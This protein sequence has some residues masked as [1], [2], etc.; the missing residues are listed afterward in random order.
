MRILTAGLAF[1]FLL[2]LSACG[3]GGSGT[4]PVNSVSLTLASPSGLIFTGQSG[5]T[6]NLTV[7]RQGTVGNV[8]L[9]VQGLPA[10]AAADIT[11]PNSS[12]AG[13]IT[14]MAPTAAAATYPL[15][16]T[17]S[18]GSVSDSATF[19][20]VVGA[21]AQI[22]ATSNGP[23]QLAMATSFQPAEWDYQ[24]FTL[25]PTATTTLQN[26]QSQHTRLQGISGGVPQKTLAAWDFT[27]L[28][29]ITQPVLGVG[30][31]SPEF[32]IAK[33]PPTLYTGNDSNNSFRDLTFQE[34]GDYS[35]ELVRYYNTGG[36]TSGDG[37]FHISPAYPQDV[38]TWWGI[39]NEP[40][41]NNKLT[42]QQYVDLYNVTVPQMQAVDPSL[43]YVA[44]ELADFGS[45]P[46]NWVPPFVNGVTAHVDVMAT[47]F[48][49]T[50]NQKDNDA[51]I[52]A[53]IPG[54]ISDVRF[55]YTQMAT[56][57]ALANVPL[58]VTE[59]NVNADF[60]KGGGISAC[61]GGAF[62]TDLRGSSAFFAAWR[63]Y[64]F[65]QFGKAGVEA[66]Y[67]WDFDADKQY[68]EVDYNT[69]AFQLS[70]WVDY[71]LARMF[72]SPP[73]ATLLDYTA[74]DKT[75]L[76]ILPVRNA[77]NSVTVMVANYALHSAGDNN[78]PGSPRTVQ[79][80]TSAFGAFASASLLTIDAS[81]NVATGPTATSVTPAA[82]INI[83]LN[84]YGVAFLTLK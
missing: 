71:W 68:G 26:L 53:T 78:G 49:S 62:V 5:T 81:T 23:F 46:Q 59:N 27:V 25:N 16:V 80:D 34:F 70:Y 64:V 48:Y 6:I 22:G 51:T 65:S 74:T 55:F 60:D 45:E 21:V 4:Q 66:L 28:D 35:Q 33:G 73:G 37:A 50:C 56:N 32:Q 79:I 57:P 20:L 36:F 42:P 41:I 75:D 58:W 82:Q 24:F 47:H 63:P 61:N 29:A 30:D 15:T 19:S 39:Y 84:G 76:E 14:F 10:G 38:I 2:L 72:P 9:Q 11:S 54:F 12:N 8:T 13:S 44:L 77:D 3:G 43:K 18:D 17:A 40:N 69:G 1:S 83:T 31:H 67:H 7:S 52:F